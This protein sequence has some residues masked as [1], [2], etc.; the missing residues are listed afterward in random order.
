M[1]F[2]RL[3]QLWIPAIA[4]GF[5]R[6]EDWIGWADRMILKLDEPPVWVIEMGT[7]SSIASVLKELASNGAAHDRATYPP[8]EETWQ[9]TVFLGFVAESY[10]RGDLQTETLA[11]ITYSLLEMYGWPWPDWLSEHELAVSTGSRLPNPASHRISEEYG[12]QI[13]ASR[14]AW[15]EL[16]AAAA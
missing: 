10:L 1:D 3:R 6:P 7:A 12:L 16:L 4:S 2:E 14:A 13:H 15:S 9:A 11:K 8:Y 5:A